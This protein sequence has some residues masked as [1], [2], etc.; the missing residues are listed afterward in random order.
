MKNQ[1]QKLVKELTRLT[2][3]KEKGTITELEDKRLSK[4]MEECITDC[5]NQ[6]PIYQTMILQAEEKLKQ[7]NIL[8][9]L[10]DQHLKC[11]IAFLENKGLMEEYQAFVNQPKKRKWFQ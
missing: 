9:D 6:I 5:F 4:I 8:M 11:M 1:T 7:T 3:K 10:A 2:K